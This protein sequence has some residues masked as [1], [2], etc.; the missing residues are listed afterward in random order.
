M[1]LALALAHTAGQQQF[2]ADF[3]T[4]VATVIPVLY[5]ALAVQIPTFVRVFRAYQALGHA[6]PG[7][8]QAR[9]QSFYRVVAAIV[10]AA[11]QFILGADVIAAGWG[12][13]LAIYALHQKQDRP[14]TQLI[15]LAS[16]ILLIA[17]ATVLPVLNYLRGLA[18]SRTPAGAG[19]NQKTAGQHGPDGEN[20]QATAADSAPGLE[21]VRCRG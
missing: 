1:T 21:P 4:V 11:L 12:E 14:L 6:M 19:S 20:T 2:N 10:A 17:G 8:R 9:W 5:L 3:Y 16:V 7:G 15:V 18:R 13:I